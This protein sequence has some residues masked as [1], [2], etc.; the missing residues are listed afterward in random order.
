MQLKD[1]RKTLV[2]VGV[3]LVS[4]LHTALSDGTLSLG[5]PSEWMSVIIAS[6]GAVLVWLVRNG[7]KKTDEK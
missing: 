5:V 1:Y 4:A 3:V 7:D 6:V 2:A